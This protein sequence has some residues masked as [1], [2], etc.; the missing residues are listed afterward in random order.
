MADVYK[1]IFSDHARH[2]TA[3]RDAS[4]SCGT[5]PSLAWLPFMDQAVTADPVGAVQVRR[6]IKC[7]KLCS[8]RKQPCMAIT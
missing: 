2:Q 4:L 6:R 3:E 8:A 5:P 1:E 7:T